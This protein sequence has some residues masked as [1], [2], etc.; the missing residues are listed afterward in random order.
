MNRRISFLLVFV[1]CGL[2]LAAECGSGYQS[3]KVLKVLEGPSK[4]AP[5]AADD[6][7]GSHAKSAR[8]IIFAA[9]NQQYELRLAPGAS[10]QAARVAAGDEVCF[11]NDGKV[12]RVVTADGKPLPGAC[13]PI[14]QSPRTQ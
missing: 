9:G 10:A 4:T 6:E 1:L 13:H 8:S 7:T 12:I 5:A 11:R 2:P 3:A 14:R